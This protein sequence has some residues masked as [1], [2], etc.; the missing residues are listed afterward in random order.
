VERSIEGA[1]IGGTISAATGGKFA[2]GAISGAIQGAMEEPSKEPS[3]YEYDAPGN[4]SCTAPTATQAAA[5]QRDFDNL[6][7]SFSAVEGN[8]PQ[9]TADDFSKIALPFTAKWGFEIG[10]NIVSNQHGYGLMDV[11]EGQCIQ[12]WQGVNI[13]NDGLSVASVHT[14]PLG[15]LPGFSGAMQYS[16]GRH[17]IV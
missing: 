16:G 11:T 17:K 3:Q 15:S 5:M 10:A 14:H 2:D 8:T 4:E 1:L 7:P 9:Q 6:I 12:N 13:P